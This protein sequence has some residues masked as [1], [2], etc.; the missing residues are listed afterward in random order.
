M[1]IT[2]DWKNKNIFIPKSYLTLIQSS[3]KEIYE[4]DVDKFRLKLKE[5]EASPDGLLFPDTHRH[6]PE[7]IVAGTILARVVEIINDYT[8]TFED[9]QYAV[10]LVGAN[11]NI[12]DVATVNQVSIRSSN[13]AGLQKVT[14]GSGVTEQDKTHIIEGVKA[15]LTTDFQNI[16]TTLTDI[17]DEVT[18]I[19]EK[20]DD[21][22]AQQN[23]QIS[24]L[25]KILGLSH[26][27][28]QLVEQQYNSD[29]LL[30]SAKIK[31]YENPTD[32][33][34]STNPISVYQITATYNNKKLVDYKVKEIT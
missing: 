34:N 13:S 2:I 20:T 6:S 1:S 31:I 10:N 5:L 19:V 15:N 32:C 7:T 17:V 12:A 16:S 26:S 22:L 9:G 23:E 28:F 27:N 4:L 14:I 29:N 8:I 11:N 3:P 18:N 30:V 25:K 24:I 33:E 21:I